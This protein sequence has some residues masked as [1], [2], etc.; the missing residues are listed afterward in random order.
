MARQY[1]IKRRL[2]IECSYNQL[3][4]LHC[5]TQHRRFNVDVALRGCDVGV[6]SEMLQNTHGNAALCQVSYERATTRVR[7]A[8]VYASTLIQC[9]DDVGERVGCETC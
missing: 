9:V 8:A 3:N 4:Q 7:T 5:T 2:E 1:A 6:R